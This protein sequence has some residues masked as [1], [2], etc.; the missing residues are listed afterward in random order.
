MRMGKGDRERR[1]ARLRPAG[2]RQRR[3][4]QRGPSAPTSPG[5]TSPPLPEEHARQLVALAVD[6]LRRGGEAQLEA[7]LAELAEPGVPGWGRAV[8]RALFSGLE[9]ELTRSWQQGWQPAEL[10]RVVARQLD[11]AAGSLATDMVAAEHRRY[12]DARIAPEWSR[13]LREL[14]ADAWWGP[15]TDHARLFAERHGLDRPRVVRLAVRVTAVLRS[16]PRLQVLCPLPG[17]ASSSA[18]AD[19]VD[20]AKLARIRHLLAKAEATEFP[21]EAEALTSRAQELMARHSIDHAAVVAESGDGGDVHGRRL[22]VDAPYESHKAALLNVIA[23]AN[24]CRAVWHRQLAMCTVLGYPGDVDAVELLFTS[25]LV[26][27]TTAMR[28]AGSTRDRHGRSTTRSFRASFLAAFADRIG[29]RLMVASH[30]GEQEAV[31]EHARAGTDLVPVLARRSE[32]VEEAFHTTF[33]EVE[34]TELSVPTNAHG[35]EAGWA[36]AD[37][38]TLHTRARVTS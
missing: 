31:R 20:P 27:A 33:P 35:W 34:Q 5:S 32:R 23:Q 1:R 12:P 6:A 9:R 15:D 11:R 28:L 13:Q 10:V 26:Q 37:A 38:A 36:A 21:E 7:A 25:L 17:Q 14:G 16:L 24:H 2:D 8:D 30:T 22:A 19:G 3:D 29:E 18:V 4:T